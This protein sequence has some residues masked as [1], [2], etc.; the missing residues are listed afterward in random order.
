[1]MAD[2]EVHNITGLE[3]GFEYISLPETFFRGCFKEI[4]RTSKRKAVTIAKNWSKEKQVE[5]ILRN[6]LSLK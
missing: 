6:Y 5:W 1:M 2:Y 3:S 4:C